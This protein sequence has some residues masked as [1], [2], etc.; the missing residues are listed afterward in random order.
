MGAVSFWGGVA[1]LVGIVLVVWKPKDVGALRF[2]AVFLFVGGA[3][4]IA[5]SAFSG[6][7]T[8]AI[9]AFALVIGALALL[10]SGSKLIKIVALII[11]AAGFIVGFLA[12]PA[13]TQSQLRETGDQSAET[14]GTVFGLIIDTI[15]NALDQ[16]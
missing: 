4:A 12:L 1:V 3:W 2:V 13:E 15:Q 11:V 9:G 8:V 5:G 16:G 14:G 6:A 10:G 7:T